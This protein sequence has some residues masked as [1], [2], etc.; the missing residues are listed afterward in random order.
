MVSAQLSKKVEKEVVFMFSSVPVSIF[1]PWKIE[2]IT[3]HI[4]CHGA[5]YCVS[6]I[7]HFRLVTYGTHSSK[8]K[9]TRLSTRGTEHSVDFLR[10]HHHLSSMAD[11]DGKSV[12]NLK[13]GDHFLCKVLIINIYTF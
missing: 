1:S 12:I 4:T 2:I 7:Q 8:R 11:V 5:R 9:D 6:R 13:Y 10:P 3:C